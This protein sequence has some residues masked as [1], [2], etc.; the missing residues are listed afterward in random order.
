MAPEG[1]RRGANDAP[2]GANSRRRGANDA[3]RGANS[4]IGGKR[5]PVRPESCADVKWPKRQLT[6]ALLSV[7]R[8]LP[9]LSGPSKRDKR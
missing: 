6:D 2:Q 9:A 3:P 5:S 7:D 4:T 8:R 1:R